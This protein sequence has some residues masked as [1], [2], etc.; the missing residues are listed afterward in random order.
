MKVNRVVTKIVV[1]LFFLLLLITIVPPYLMGDQAKLQHIYLAFH[2][3]WEMIFPIILIL[4]FISLLIICVS[5]KYREP[6]LNWLLVLNTVILTAY[7][8]AI[9][10]R[11]AHLS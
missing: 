3:K 5:K 9:F 7:G 1:R 8:I 6:D 11:I 4:G 2:H 10:I